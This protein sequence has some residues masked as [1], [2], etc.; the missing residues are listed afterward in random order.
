MN[1]RKAYFKGSFYPKECLKLKAYFQTFTN[2]MFK[3][4]K[5]SIPKN[6][7][8]IISPH[9]GYI[10]SGFTANMGYYFLSKNQN[11]KRVIVIGASHRYYF[12]GISGSYFEEFQT[13]CK[14]IKIDT[15][16]LI[17][18][19]K[20]HKINF[21]EKAHQ[22]EH[23]TETQ[24]P[25]I[26][27]YF[28][29][30]KLIELIYSNIEEKELSSIISTILADKENGLVISTDLSHFY[31]EEEALKYDKIC[32]NAISK[33]NANYLKGCKACGLLGVK[34]LLLSTQKKSFKIDILD[35]RTSS[36]YNN[37]KNSVVGYLSAIISKK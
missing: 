8:A 1:I 37:N 6:P 31:K 15:D 33:N 24:A 11:I 2:Y 23:S 29:N 19:A 4:K 20:K 25:F 10:Y 27:Y 35:Y 26:E 3:F 18:L 30:I 5:I 17:F 22:K 9:A 21:I 36:S 34:A 32:F 13:P 7:I 28:K 12:N 16:Y 14:N